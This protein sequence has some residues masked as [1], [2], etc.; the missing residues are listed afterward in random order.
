M[1]H[2]KTHSPPACSSWDY[3]H[4]M[5]NYDENKERNNTFKPW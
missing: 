5:K 2:K 4:E 1:D 3:F